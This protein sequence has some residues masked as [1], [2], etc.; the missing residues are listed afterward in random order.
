MV[1]PPIA[2]AP[3][4]LTLAGRWCGF[5]EFCFDSLQ[6]GGNYSLPFLEF[7]EQIERQLQ[8]EARIARAHLGNHS[9]LALDSSNSLRYM[10]LGHF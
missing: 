6:V 5:L 1:Q 10:P 9:P 4:E 3:S 8:T 7:L 2:A